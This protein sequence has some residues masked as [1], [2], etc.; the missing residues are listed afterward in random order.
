MEY[1]SLILSL[2][3]ISIV[4]WI[5]AL[6][7]VYRLI[8]IHNKHSQSHLKEEAFFVFPRLCTPAF[9]ATIVF[10]TLLLVLNKALL[11]TG[12]WIYIKFFVVSLIILLH[13]QCKIDLY[14]CNRNLLSKKSSTLAYHSYMPLVLFSVVAI[15]TITKLF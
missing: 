4:V 11:E 12:F 3:L 10:G 2:H 14:T 9:I 6:S 15:L 8:F 7:W 1:Y 5:T 13:H